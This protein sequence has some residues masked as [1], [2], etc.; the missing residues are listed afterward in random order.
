M[1]VRKVRKNTD[2]QIIDASKGFVKDGK[3]NKLRACDIKR[4][5][6]AVIKR[7]NIEKYSRVVSREEIREND[8]NLNIPRY[9]NSSEEDEIYDIYASMYGGIPNA[10]IE[11]FEEY[12]D[13]F[14]N[15]RK[16]LFVKESSNYSKLVTENAKEFI[17]NMQML[18]AI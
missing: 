9:V 8:Y 10:E 2:V 11:K 6:D 7:E 13:T 1:I 16:D 3:N 18:K 5:V 15:L 12:W 14:P 4:I 17:K